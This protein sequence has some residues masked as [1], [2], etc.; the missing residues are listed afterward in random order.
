MTGARTFFEGLEARADTSRIDGID[1]SYLFDVEGEGQWL[2]EVRNGAVR[3]TE[4][5]AKADV[6]ISVSGETFSRIASGQQ[7][8]VT[9]YMTGKLKISG[10][11]GAA[12]KLQKIFS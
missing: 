11:T 8:P 12:L 10:D 1:H 3:V 7:N 9:A 2:V 5:A 6:T 4:G